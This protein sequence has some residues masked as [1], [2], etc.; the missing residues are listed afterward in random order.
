ME[1]FDE[2]S[3]HEIEED[4]NLME[5]KSIVPIELKHAPQ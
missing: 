4:V 5:R 3:E 2:R 1:D